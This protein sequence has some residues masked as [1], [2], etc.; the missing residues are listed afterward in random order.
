M[1]ENKVNTLAFKLG[2]C[3]Y[4]SENVNIQNNN[5][6]LNQTGVVVPSKGLE[7]SRP[8]GHW[9]LK[10]ARLP[11]PPTGLAEGKYTISV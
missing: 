11:I 9:S 8:C 7:P 4:L 5:S 6:R 10:P 2:L 1:H 3:H